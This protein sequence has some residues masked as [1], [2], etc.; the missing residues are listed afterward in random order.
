MI[1]KSAQKYNL[2]QKVVDEIYNETKSIVEGLGY[3]LVDIEYSEMYKSLQ[4]FVLIWKKEKIQF[5]DCE[6][7]H[8]LISEML[9]K[10][11][12]DFP[13]QYTLNISS[14]GLD[15]PIV[16]DDDFRRN[17][18]EEIIDSIVKKYGVLV[19]YDDENVVL[20]NAKNEEFVIKRKGNKF[21]PYIRF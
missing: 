13:E 9:D 21:E 19:K 1:H 20:K 17:L 8:P 18:D 4:V 12:G 3:E 10:F 7:V 5:E 15:R 16:T 11:D 6:K 14:V 2:S